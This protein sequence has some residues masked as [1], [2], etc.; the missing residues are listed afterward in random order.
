[1]ARV[2]LN[3]AEAGRATGRVE[4][5]GEL[6]GQAAAHYRK[7]GEP[8][9]EIRALEGLAALA[10][11]Q[12]RT[13]DEAGYLARIVEIYQAGGAGER[14]VSYQERICELTDPS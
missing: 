6:F 9:A 8:S 2:R 14:A 5:A 11:D 3:L 10:R 12:S 13:G 7:H 1:M 4:Q